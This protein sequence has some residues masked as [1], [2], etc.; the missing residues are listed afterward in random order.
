MLFRS[1]LVEKVDVGPFTYE[2]G[3][4]GSDA[5]SLKSTERSSSLVMKPQEDFSTYS[6]LPSDGYSPQV[7]YGAYEGIH[8]QQFGRG[9]SMYQPSPPNR[10]MYQYSSGSPSSSIKARSNQI[11]TWTSYRN[12]SSEGHHNQGMPGRTSLPSIS[13]PSPLLVDRKSVV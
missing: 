10:G 4:L 13:S 2:R 11:P 8:S 6:Y 9:N 5:E 7:Q 12:G 1:E 3:R